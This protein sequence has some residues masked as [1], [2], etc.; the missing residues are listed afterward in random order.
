MVVL[1]V[2]GCW[3]FIT[4][5]MLGLLFKAFYSMI[6]MCAEDSSSLALVLAHAAP[7]HSEPAVA[8]PLDGHALVLAHGAAFHSEPDVAL[9]LDGQDCTF[10][11]TYHQA[12]RIDYT[13]FPHLHDR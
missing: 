12:S 9:P 8:L 2:L 4:P 1:N 13:I 5:K 7:I 11:L 10:G 3:S 6:S